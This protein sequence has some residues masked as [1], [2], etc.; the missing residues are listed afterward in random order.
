MVTN[1]ARE[2]CNRWLKHRAIKTYENDVAC[3]INVR[4]TNLDGSQNLHID[5]CIYYDMLADEEFIST[6]TVCDFVAFPGFPEWYDK[7]ENRPITVSHS[8]PIGEKLVLT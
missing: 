3:I 8:Q 5:H 7:N 2:G 4:A 1:L 6:C